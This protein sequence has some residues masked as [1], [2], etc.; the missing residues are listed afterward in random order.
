MRKEP[1][2]YYFEDFEVGDTF[3]SPARTVT[4]ADIVNFAGLSAD[5]NALHV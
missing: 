5:Y 2:K 1:V 4:E 3:T